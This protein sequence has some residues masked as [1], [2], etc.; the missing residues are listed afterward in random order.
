MPW[1]N[2][3]SETTAHTHKL[4]T[5]RA[6]HEKWRIL[7]RRCNSVITNIFFFLVNVPSVTFWDASHWLSYVGV[8]VD[9]NTSTLRLMANNESISALVI[10]M[11]LES[12]AQAN[13][14]ASRTWR[15]VWRWTFNIIFFISPSHILISPGGGP[16]PGHPPASAPGPRCTAAPGGGRSGGRRHRVPEVTRPC[17]VIMC[18]V[19]VLMCH[20]KVLMYHVLS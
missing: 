16:R 1:L 3:S 12:I 5:L 20:V 13:Y 14:L 11:A 7:L 19:K 15:L 2:V 18:H 9:G 10:D 4:H 17:N 6:L 8:I